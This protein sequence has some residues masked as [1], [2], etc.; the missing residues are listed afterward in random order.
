MVRRPVPDSSGL[1]SG[2]ALV[3]LA[4]CSFAGSD[5]TIKYLGGFVPVLV[6]LWARYIFQSGVM[7]TWH[8]TRSGSF[9][10]KTR[11]PMLQAIRG[12]LLLCNSTASFYGVQHVPLAEFTALVLLAPVATTVLAAVVLKEPMPPARWILVAFG[13]AG[14]LAVVRPTGE[15]SIGWGALLPIFAALCYAVFQLV[16]RR[17]AAID[18]LILTNFLSALFITCALGLVLWFLPLDIVPTLR[19][20]N[21]AHWAL[22]LLIGTLATLGQ[23]S[24]AAAVRTAP[25]SL[26]MPFAYAQIGFAAS[27][28]AVL[29]HHA[30]DRWTVGGICLIVLGGVGTVL[31]GGRASLLR[32]LRPK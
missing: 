26:L 29:F 32:L 13:V 10:F 8:Y 2:I 23:V 12:I 18:D 5:A 20:M 24:M 27:I 31:L 9:K 16:T 1:G 19:S 7:A 17:V 14:M 21:T 6:L 3:L 28:S 11:A 15:G 30:P 4:S 25:L 22:L